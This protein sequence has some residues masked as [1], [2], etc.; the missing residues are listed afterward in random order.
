MS[1][2]KYLFLPTPP[3]IQSEF[4]KIVTDFLQMNL[5]RYFLERINR[6][7]EHVRI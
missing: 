3:K 7:N 4:E 1:R 5:L 2:K 6:R